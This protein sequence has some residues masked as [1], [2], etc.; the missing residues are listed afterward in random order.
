MTI[1]AQTT[2]DQYLPATDVD[3]RLWSEDLQ[4]FISEWKPLPENRTISF[5]FYEAEI[6]YDPEPL[7]NTFF[8]YLVAIIFFVVLSLG[9]LKLYYSARNQKNPIPP[10]L[11]RYMNK[12]NRKKINGAVDDRL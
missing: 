3:Y 8:T 2:I 10:E 9:A 7:Q 6:P 4:E 11:L 1:S 12:K 5:G